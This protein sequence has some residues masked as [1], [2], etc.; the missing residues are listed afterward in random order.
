MVTVVNVRN[1]KRGWENDDRYVY[2]GRSCYGL[3]GNGWGNPI[4]LHEDTPL[5]RF[6]LIEAYKR[7]FMADEQ[8]E[9]RERALRELPGKILV[10][11]CAPKL[12]HGDVLADYVNEHAQENCH[13][14]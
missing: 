3:T 5:A 2:I 8:C 10:C 11:W 14:G 13:V 9:L 4:K 12:C 7:W 6:A 1:L